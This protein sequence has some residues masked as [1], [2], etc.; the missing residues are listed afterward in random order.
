MQTALLDMCSIIHFGQ[1]VKDKHNKEDSKAKERC[2]KVVF[3]F[4]V[5]LV[6]SKKELL[7]E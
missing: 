1:F 5:F 7:A 3:V 6:L 4:D 2:Q